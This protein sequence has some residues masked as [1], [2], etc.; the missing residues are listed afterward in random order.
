MT[1]KNIFIACC[2]LL[3]TTSAH[4]QDLLENVNIEWQDLEESLKDNPEQKNLFIFIYADW[5]EYCKKTVETTLSNEEFANCINEQFIPIKLNANSYETIHI[6]DTDFEYDEESGYHGLP[7]VLLGGT[8]KFPT[9]MF[10][11]PDFGEISKIS[12]HQSDLEGLIKYIDYIGTNK[13]KEISWADY[14]K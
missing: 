2:M 5:C 11:T 8:M 12:G 1:I 6:L 14:I 9:M 10:M 4:A 7:I 3:L 13:Y